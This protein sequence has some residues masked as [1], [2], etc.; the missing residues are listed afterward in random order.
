MDKFVSEKQLQEAQ[1]QIKLFN[2][3]Q[4]RL[5]NYKKELGYHL[6]GFIEFTFR[7]RNERTVFAGYFVDK[8]DVKRLVLSETICSKDDVF[9]KSLGKLIAVRKAL[10]MKIDDI[11]EVVE[12]KNKLESTI[13]NNIAVSGTTPFSAS[14]IMTYIQQQY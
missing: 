11:V 7:Q 14:D 5:E 6:D 13:K 10:G 4:D 12:P 9:D 1:E 8:G 3:R 2:E